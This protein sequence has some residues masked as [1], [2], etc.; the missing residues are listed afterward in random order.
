MF[1]PLVINSLISIAY[2]CP[3]EHE[4]QLL[5]QFEITERLKLNLRA[6]S[7]NLMNHPVFNGPATTVGLA[8]LGQIGS[9]A[10][11]SRQTEVVL[12]VLF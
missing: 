4:I 12:R 6:S 8:N 7:F 9:Q 1:I 3:L 11:L 10:N 5:K 2:A